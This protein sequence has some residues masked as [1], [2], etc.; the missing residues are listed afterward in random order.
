MKIGWSTPWWRWNTKELYF[1]ETDFLRK[2]V[3]IRS[4]SW[5]QSGTFS[6]TR[7]LKKL[8]Y[9][10]FQL[11]KKIALF[12]FKTQQGTWRFGCLVITLWFLTDLLYF[13]LIKWRLLLSILQLNFPS[14]CQSVSIYKKFYS[15]VEG[16]KFSYSDNSLPS[17]RNENTFGTRKYSVALWSSKFFFSV[18]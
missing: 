13:R 15:E 8:P 1:E 18:K 16:K 14:V 3:R 6:G 7:T 5:S 2:E 11:S 4:F 9:C 10:I 17:P 12:E